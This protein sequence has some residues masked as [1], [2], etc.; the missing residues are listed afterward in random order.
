[1]INSDKIERQKE[2]KEWFKTQSIQYFHDLSNDKF[3]DDIIFNKKEN[4]YYVEIGVLDGWQ[5]SQSIHF[6][7]LKNWNGIVV[8]PTP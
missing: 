6:E 5:H 8:E 2:M 7:Y 3:Y 1:M 4:G